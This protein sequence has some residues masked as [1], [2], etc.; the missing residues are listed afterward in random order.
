MG[1]T[2]QEFLQE[3]VDVVNERNDTHGKATADFDRIAALWNVLFA[4]KL[5]QPFESDDV[6]TAMICLKLS[7]IT[8]NP[9]HKDSWQDIAGYAAC[10]WECRDDG[11][12]ADQ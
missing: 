1:Q 3:I 10:G 6:A 11:R 7:R 9:G 5:N 2:K 8:W 12:T 4:G